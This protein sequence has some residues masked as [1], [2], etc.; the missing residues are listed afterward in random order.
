MSKKVGLMT[1][2]KY[3]N[4]GTSLQATALYKTISDLGY[5]PE[6][7][8]YEPK[9]TLETENSSIIRYSVKKA[10]NVVNRLLNKAYSSAEREKLYNNYLSARITETDNCKLFS[11][12][13]SLDHDA[14]V[15]GSDQIWSP[16][17]FDAHYFLD[18]VN[19]KEKMIAYA[20]SIGSNEISNPNIK[21]NMKRLISRFEH[22]SVREQKGVQII[23]DL[24]DKTAEHVLDPTLLLNSDEWNNYANT[25][26]KIGG[27][28]IIC[29]FLSNPEKYRGYVKRL[30][31]KTGIKFYEIPVFQGQLKYA[32]DFEV[33]PSEFVSLIKHAKYVCTD[34]FHGMLFATQYNT[35]FSV[36]KRFKDKDSK[37]QNSRVTGFLDKM[38]LMDRLISPKTVPDS[39]VLECDFSSA[40]EILNKEREKSLNYLKA[41][42]ESATNSKPAD[43]VITGLCCGCGA[44]AAV[45]KT[46]AVSVSLNEEGFYHYSIDQSK[47]VKCGMCRSVC[48]FAESRGESLRNATSLSAYKS[49]NTE[50]LKKSSSGGF[51]NDMVS[52]LINDGYYVCGCTYDNATEKARHIIISPDKKEDISLLQG[53]KYIQSKTDDVFNSVADIAKENKLVFIGTPCQS[54][55]LDLFLTKKGVRENVIII[56]LICHGVPTNHLWHKYLKENGIKNSSKVLFR[57]KSFEWRNITITLENND[58]SLHYNEDDDDFYSFFKKGHCYME[59]C[60][61]CIYRENSCADIRIGDYWGPKFVGDTTGVSMV[62]VVNERGSHLVEK[63][64]NNTQFDLSEYWT[65]QFPYNPPKPIFRKALIK[66]LAQ[67]DITLSQIRKRYCAFF[68]KRSKLYRLAKK[69]LRRG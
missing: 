21:E 50:T 61:D 69:I 22:L 30:S 62:L 12:L 26:R 10:K 24:T 65:V 54:A 9:G 37:N 29:Y 3:L 64:G 52:M 41:S 2:Y 4:Y 60:F 46:G 8:N 28:Y 66:E 6:F 20:P 68:E 42:L 11:H 55:G 51:S 49:N 31:Q 15:C 17:C 25:E 32:P 18:F 33:G 45:C 40:M 7:I 35:P 1:W 48:P 47:C 67:D 43:Y 44:C 63:L 27:D 34:S 56:D 5:S 38:N 36:F 53:S 23:K 57:D 59:T 19:Q 13:Q 16:L 39:S 14:F 58:K